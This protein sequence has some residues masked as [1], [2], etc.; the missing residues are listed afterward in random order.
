MEESDYDSLVHGKSFC[1]LFTVY[2]R[3]MFTSVH[4]KS[5]DIIRRRGYSVTM[6]SPGRRKKYFEEDKYKYEYLLFDH[7]L[8]AVYSTIVSTH[9]DTRTHM[10]RTQHHITPNRLNTMVIKIMYSNSQSPVNVVV[11]LVRLFIAPSGQLSR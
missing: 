9:T 2:V 7:L 10:M 11:A 3:L 5:N 6:I 8:Y 1:C 4:H